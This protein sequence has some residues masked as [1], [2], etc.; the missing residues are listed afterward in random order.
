M[1][2]DSEGKSQSCFGAEVN[3]NIPDGL[4]PKEIDAIRHSHADAL[5]VVVIAK[6]ADLEKSRRASTECNASSSQNL[7][8]TDTDLDG[9]AIDKQALVRVPPLKKGGCRSK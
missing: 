1:A 8:P 6:A 7:G 5:K 2:A 4:G 9:L 3:W